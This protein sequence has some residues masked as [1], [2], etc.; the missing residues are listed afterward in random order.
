VAING[1]NIDELIEI[2]LNKFPHDSPLTYFDREFK[3]V[4]NVD[5]FSR[6]FQKT[7]GY[8]V[9]REREFDI[10]LI[11]LEDL[12]TCFIEAVR[13]FMG[14]DNLVLVNENLSVNKE[15]NVIYQIVKN[16]IKFP[17]SFLDKIYFSKFSRHFYTDEELNG[18]KKRWLRLS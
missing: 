8:Q 3:G 10:L 11:R 15:Y 5:I 9:Y 6:D 2:F 14:I 18:F 1:S 7:K 12:N 16:S 13:E 4:L 17:E